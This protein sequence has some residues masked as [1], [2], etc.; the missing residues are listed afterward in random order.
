MSRAQRDKIKVLKTNLVRIAFGFSIVLACTLYFK[1][2]YSRNFSVV[3]TSYNCA[4]GR[5]VAKA[6]IENYSESST[7]LF[8]RVTALEELWVGDAKVNK[9]IAS[10]L[11]EITLA[12][13]ATESFQLAINVSEKPDR[14]L[15]RVSAK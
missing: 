13:G 7:V 3:E 9:Q 1:Y 8:M 2:L 10:E 14:I 15:I 4:M 5:C 12:G 6:L 11:T